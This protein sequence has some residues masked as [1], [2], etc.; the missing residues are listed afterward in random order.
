[1]LRVENLSALGGKVAFFDLVG[2]IR[3]VIR[4]PLLLLMQHL[5][6]LLNEFIGGLIRAP[7][8][9]LLDERFQLGLETNRHTC[10]LPFLWRAFASHYS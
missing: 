3:M 7:F 9:V 5:N 6:S 2:D 10:N 1:L 4:Q 8:H